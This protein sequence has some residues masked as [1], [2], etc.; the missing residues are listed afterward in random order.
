MCA[1]YTAFATSGDEAN[2]RRGERKILRLLLLLVEETASVL[3]RARR[4]VDEGGPILAEIVGRGGGRSQIRPPGATKKVAMS[5][6]TG[7]VLFCA[8]HS[9]AW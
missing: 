3:N 2:E 5:I 4:A 7:T 6:E 8:G 9:R 1:R